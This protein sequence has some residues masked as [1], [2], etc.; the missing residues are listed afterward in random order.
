MKNERRLFSMEYNAIEKQT[1]DILGRT[2]F[3]AIKKDEIVSIT[4]ML[5]NM[6]PEVAREA[7]KQFPELAKLLGNSLLEYKEMLSKIVES[8]DESIQQVYST[9]D[10]A[11]SD[12]EVGRAEYLSFAE[13]IRDDYSK[14]LDKEGLT[15]E[16]RSFLQLCFYITPAV[17]HTD[18]CNYCF[19]YI[20][21]IK[22][23]VIIHRHDSQS[24]TMPRFM[25]IGTESLRHL[26][27][28]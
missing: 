14:C 25:L 12:A 5:S 1:L 9:A 26:I 7:I 21:N 28:T 10:K 24:T 18:N 16:E 15:A 17:H 13:K 11:M 27:K 6:R 19:F 8:D 3:K 20:G 22:H 4:S 2:D 23:A